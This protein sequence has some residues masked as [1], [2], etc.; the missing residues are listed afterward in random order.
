M[1]GAEEDSY[2]KIHIVTEKCTMRPG[3]GKSSFYS[4]HN[5]AGIRK[6]SFIDAK[7]KEKF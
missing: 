5:K 1:S 3:V 6:D 4:H 2:S 7:S